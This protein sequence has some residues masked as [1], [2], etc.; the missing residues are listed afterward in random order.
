M[1]GSH[2][3]PATSITRAVRSGSGNPHVIRDPVAPK[4]RTARNAWYLS[5]LVLGKISEAEYLAMPLVSESSAWQAVAMGLRA[6]LADRPADAL[7]AYRTCST[8]IR[9]MSRW[10][11]SPRGACGRWRSRVLEDV[12]IDSQGQSRGESCQ[13]TGALRLCART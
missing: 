5:G 3:R 6:E 2:K 1:A 9:W 13:P 11:C 10:N 4:R 8:A 12:D 7:D